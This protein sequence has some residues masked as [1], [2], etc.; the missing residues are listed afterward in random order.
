MNKTSRHIRLTIKQNKIKTPLQISLYMREGS[1]RLTKLSYKESIEQLINWCWYFNT[2]SHP[3]NTEKRRITVHQ[4][5]VHLSHNEKVVI[6]RQEKKL[7]DKV[8]SSK[9]VQE[10]V[11]KTQAEKNIDNTAVSIAAELKQ[12][13]SMQQQGFLSVDEFNQA[14]KKLLNN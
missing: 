1:N 14:K 12:L 5:R 4:D 8:L 7:I 11:D 3:Q 10:D 13:V 2:I 9:S 6:A